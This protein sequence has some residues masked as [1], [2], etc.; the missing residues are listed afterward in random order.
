MAEKIGI[1]AVVSILVLAICL[2]AFNIKG[3][4][5]Y[6]PDIINTVTTTNATPTNILT[7]SLATGQ[8]IRIVVDMLA[9]SGN[10]RFR[11]RKTACIKNI[12]GTLTVLGGTVTDIV[13]PVSDAGLADAAFNITT[14]GT[15]VIVPVT[16][17]AATTIV[18]NSNATY[19]LN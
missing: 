2:W 9:S 5:A 18:W 16:G 7:V 8:T 1:S 11:G 15:T 12:S 3:T 13:T 19:I 10:N 14:S 17:I 4:K 6:D